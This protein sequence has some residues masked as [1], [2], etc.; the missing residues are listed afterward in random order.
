MN[1]LQLLLG[2]LA[3]ECLEVAKEALKAQQFG[4]DSTYIGSSN[5]DRIR[6]ELDDMN[7]IV[8]MLNDEFNLGYV[9]DAERIFKKKIKVNKFAEYSKAEGFVS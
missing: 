5:E 7:A 9:P 1:R 2:K 6:Q 4:L 8:E 3:E